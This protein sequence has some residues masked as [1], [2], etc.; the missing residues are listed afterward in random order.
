MEK[1]KQ[2]PKTEILG[3]VTDI[4]N[5]KSELARVCRIVRMSKSQ[6]ENATFSRKDNAILF[7][8]QAVFL[9]PQ[10]HSRVQTN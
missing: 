8:Y 9:L 5:L 2:L 7:S 6:C 4:A 3:N 1:N 10:Q